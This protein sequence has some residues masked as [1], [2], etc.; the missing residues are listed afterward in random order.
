[1][2]LSWSTFALEIVNFLILVWILKRFL[3]KPVLGV[4][5]RRRAGIE[6]VLA[7][8]GEERAAAQALK[9][10]YES[11]LTAWDRERAAAREGLAAELDQRRSQELAALQDELEQQREKARVGE[12]RRRADAQREMAATALALGARFA[13][14]L[15]E[16]G[17]CPEVESRLVELAIGELRR[18][19]PER[20][21]ALR[22]TR[23][24]AP[25]EIAVTTAFP[26]AEDQGRRLEARLREVTG[27]DLPVRFD[28]DDS[29]L[30]GLRV[31][32]G[33]WVLGMSLRD[34]LQGFA[35][36]ADAG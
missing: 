30:A 21:A 35:E 2:E 5:A 3:Y 34:E 18:L 15:L 19:P 20:L 7:Q 23:A 29:L 33:A 13:T 31:T 1:M 27:L 25:D 11:R 14:R 12:A 16:Q 9:A 17:A 36:T 4:I 24:M 26:L 10:D 32:A 28:L 8:A 22:N 6:S